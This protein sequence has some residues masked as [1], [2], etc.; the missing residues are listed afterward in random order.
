MICKYMRHRKMLNLLSTRRPTCTL[1]PYQ[2]FTIYCLYEKNNA[3]QGASAPMKHG[4]RLI[5]CKPITSVLF[6]RSCVNDR[7]TYR[8]AIDTVPDV[9]ANINCYFDDGCIP[10]NNAAP[11]KLFN[12]SFCTRINFYTNKVINTWNDLP[13]SVNF[14]SLSTFKCYLEISVSQLHAK[15]VEHPSS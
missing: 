14:S 13:A 1:Q 3:K 11:L 2:L 12:I 4:E 5:L 8:N 10:C 9:K 7:I 6:T 15:A